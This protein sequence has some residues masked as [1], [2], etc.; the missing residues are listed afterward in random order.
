[1][2]RKIL[3]ISWLIVFA[4]PLLLHAQKHPCMMLSPE[5]VVEIRKHLGTVPLFDLS[6]QQAIKEVDA[7]IE[8]GVSVPVPKDLAGGYTHEQHKQ[9]FFLLQKA[10]TI[11]QLTGEE[12]YAIH[13]REVFMAYAEMYPKLDLHPAT[14]S[15]ARGK[16][17]WQCL[18]DANW[19]VYM[20]QAYDC[21][22]DWLTAAER[23][24]LET[25]L[26]RPFADFLSIENPKF[27]NRIHNHSTWGNAGVG[28]MGIVMGDEELIN[29][30]LYGLNGAQTFGEQQDNDGG[31]I[32]IPGQDKA[33]F[34][35]NIDHAFSPDGYYTEGP[36]YHRY[37][38]FPFIVF[39][40][41]LENYYPDKQIFAYRD[42]LMVNSIYA[43]LNQTDAG[44]TFFPINDAQKGMSYLSR[45]LVTAVDICYYYGGTDASL[46]S[47][48][49]EQGRVLLDETGFQ[50]AQDLAKGQATP[51]IRTSQELS[52][53]ANGD[54]G[55]I[56]ILRTPQDM[57]LLMKYS[58]QGM[59]HGHFD[60]LSFSYYD[61][62]SEVLQD[63]GADHIA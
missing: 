11:F 52:D 42:S 48:A 51:F 60:K 39:A 40:R 62:A 17:F 12:K 57:T 24:K 31:F 33:G 16:I 21:I 4:I 2:V 25:Q 13:M 27:F 50:V 58:A 20:S 46:L 44:G 18:N 5:S 1:M 32:N 49:Q 45:E 30:A 59:G 9:N 53:G 19:L 47:I 63:Y 54:E 61:G 26:F 28:M 55:A 8:K 37:A 10:G 41:A 6:L 29:R 35:A 23:E 38:I 56:G 3:F 15:Y 34:L 36:Y 22:Y 43:L 14:R 7:A